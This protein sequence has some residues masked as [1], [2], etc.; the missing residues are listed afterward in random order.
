MKFRILSAILRSPWAIDEQFAIA[1]G[2]IIAGLLNGYEIDDSSFDAKEDPASIPFAISAAASGNKKYSV[3]DEA[4]R[5]SIAVIPVR[6]ALMK[7]DQD[8]GPV[9]MDTLSDRILEAD[10]HPNIDSMILY[11]DSPGGTV[12]GTQACADRVKATRKPVIAFIDGMMCSAALW[13]GSSADQV[14]AQNSTTQ[15]GSI[16]VMMSFADMQPMWEAKGVKFHRINADQSSDKNKEFTDALAGDYEAIK[17]EMLN[18]LADQFINAVKKNRPGIS[19]EEVFTGKVYF[20]EDAL[21]LGLI[22]EI[23]S[24][25][26]AVERA[27]ELSLERKVAATSL[28]PQKQPIEM[29]QLTMLTALL[30]VAALES[31]DDGVFLNEEQ[32][33]A[34]EDRLAADADA[35]Q[36]ANQATETVDTLNARI[37]ELEADLAEARKLPGAVTATTVVSTDNLEVKE[38]INAKLEDLPMAERMAILSKE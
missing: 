19:S 22:D 10:Q 21:A 2:G 29:K 26:L 9:G 38:D 32:L 16:G 20:A 25:E 31:T 7:E 33:A 3:Y 35:L 18:P 4:P 6:G 1:H 36:A 11:I 13:I 24:L 30:A 34:I 8:C 23:G 5:G 12:D 27:S 17:K 37:T 15:I 28:N 14:I